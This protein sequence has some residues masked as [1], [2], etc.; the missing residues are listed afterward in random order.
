[1]VATPPSGGGSAP[2]I[3]GAG[4]G[5]SDEGADSVMFFAGGGATEGGQVGVADTRCPGG[6]GRVPE[7]GAASVS[8][9]W[10]HEG[11]QM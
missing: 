1:M 11:S 2:A 10:E 4:G 8:E 7:N 9:Q 5:K 3:N 6:G